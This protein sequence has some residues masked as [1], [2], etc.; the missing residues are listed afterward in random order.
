MLADFQRFKQ[1]KMSKKQTTPTKPVYISSV[2]GRYVTR[3]YA[4][5]HPNTTVRMTVR[6]GK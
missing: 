6:K 1:I 4:V 5:A 3:P 2:T